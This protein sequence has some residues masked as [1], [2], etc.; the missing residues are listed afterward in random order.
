MHKILVEK[1]KLNIS[2]LN[3]PTHLAD[4]KV[5]ILRVEE[6]CTLPGK[7]RMNKE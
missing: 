3:V 5:S 7:K 6:K 4:R 1:M 2:L